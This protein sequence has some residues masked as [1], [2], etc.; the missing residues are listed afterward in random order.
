MIRM[1]TGLRGG[2]AMALLLAAGAAAAQAPPPAAVS[3]PGAAPI[4][5]PA[6]LAPDAPREA[7][8][9]WLAQNLPASRGRQVYINGG[10]AFWVEHEDV[11][12]KNSMLVTATIESENIADSQLTWRSAYQV[13][14]FDCE[15]QQQYH[16]YLTHYVGNGLTGEVTKDAPLIKR[17]EF[18]PPTAMDFAHVRAVCLPAY[19]RVRKRTYTVTVPAG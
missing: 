3:Q 8:G 19:D 15:K 2:A 7:I 9:A 6:L 16:I 5:P 1:T 12:S 13:T 11:D 18:V 4:A 17:S 14:Q 10:E